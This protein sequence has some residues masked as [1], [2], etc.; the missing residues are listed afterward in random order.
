M[1]GERGSDESKRRAKFYY[2]FIIAGAVEEQAGL[3]NLRA[4][5]QANAHPMHRDELHKESGFAV[6]VG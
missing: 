1:W 4:E 5:K 6:I 3:K 2:T